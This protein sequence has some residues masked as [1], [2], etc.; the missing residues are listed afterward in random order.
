MGEKETEAGQADQCCFVITPIGG[1]GSSTRRAANGLIA[2][3]IEPTLSEMGFTVEVAHTIARAGS[4][5]N[6]VIERLLKAHLVVANLTAL[7][8]NVMYELAVRHA[9]RRP[10]VTVAEVGTELP[11]DL[12]DERTIFYHNDMRG[13]TELRASLDKAVREAMKSYPPDNPIYRAAEHA[14]MREVAVRDTEQYLMEQIDAIEHAISRLFLAQG[15]PRRMTS[16]KPYDRALHS[17]EGAAYRTVRLL[18]KTSH[19]EAQAFV[20]EL[21][22]HASIRNAT[23]DAT[24][25]EAVVH[26]EFFHFVELELLRIFAREQGVDVQSA[27]GLDE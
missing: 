27:R 19:T 2:S 4:I 6:Q 26:V 5:T 17:R 24:G 3:V 21:D 11:F 10:V 16:R 7:N 18:L 12:S 22:R 20:A 14:V 1:R 8:P 23:V 9:K 25:D 15:K 13:V